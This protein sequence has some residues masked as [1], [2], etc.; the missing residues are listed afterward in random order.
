MNTSP[1]Q[2]AES[3]LRDMLFAVVD[4]ET[5]GFKPETNR[6]VQ[7]AAIDDDN[8]LGWAVARGRVDIE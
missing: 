8:K 1:T 2:T 5:T 4:F 6:I 7:L 3:S